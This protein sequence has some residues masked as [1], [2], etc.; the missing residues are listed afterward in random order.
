VLSVPLREFG[1]AD[2]LAG[3][4]AAAQLRIWLNNPKPC[5]TTLALAENVFTCTLNSC[6]AT[7]SDR[8]SASQHLREHHPELAR[9]LN[10][11]ELREV[12]PRLRLPR[13]IFRCSHC[14]HYQQSDDSARDPTGGIY[15]HLVKEH[16]DRRHSFIV[17]RDAEVIRRDVLATLPETYFCRWAL[18]YPQFERRDHLYPTRD[19]VISH[20]ISEHWT[21][22]FVQ[23]Q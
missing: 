17:V 22:V 7:V 3:H 2:V 14:L 1:D 12:F 8:A 19:E 10:Y 6:G 15:E 11:D 9:Q 20:V 13:Q 18:R 16:P 21:D 5:S 4:L 23:E